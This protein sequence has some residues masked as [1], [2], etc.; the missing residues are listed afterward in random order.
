MRH[1]ILHIGMHKTG[2]S[3]IQQALFRGR[4]TAAEAGVWY[5]DERPG[6]H[7]EAVKIAFAEE[8]AS[9]SALRSFADAEGLPAAAA[10]MRDKIARFLDASPGPLLVISGEGMLGLAS[11]DVARLMAFMTARVD[12]V[13]VYAMVRP[14]RSLAV[15]R[16]QQH[17]RKGSPIIGLNRVS[18][19]FYR[20][21]FEAW[22][23]AAGDR[24]MLRRYSPVD[25]RDGCSLTTFLHDIGAPPELR[26]ALDAPRT[27]VS[28][29]ALA[30]ALIVAAGPQLGPRV[31]RLLGDLSGPPLTVPAA[32]LARE[33]RDADAEPDIAWMEAQLGRSFADL[34]PEVPAAELES[35]P[36]LTDWLQRQLGSVSGSDLNRLAAFLLAQLANPAPPVTARERAER[37][38]SQPVS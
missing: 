38:L 17:D 6:N 33:L 35:A 28:R 5:F 9:R 36:T 34:E 20:R 4:E 27:N 19:P 15:S 10:A 11:A 21:R 2:T 24:M 1:L 3:T 23:A 30:L 18:M 8:L 7:S 16:L 12:R 32:V 22:I 13:T 31:A 26:H 14:P 25:L 29:P 37:T